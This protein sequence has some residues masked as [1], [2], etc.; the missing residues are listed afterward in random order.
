[1][2][3]TRRG[4]Q[5]LTG[6]GLEDKRKL[7]DGAFWTLLLGSTPY[8]NAQLNRVPSGTGISGALATTEV[9]TAGDLTMGWPICT[10]YFDLTVPGKIRKQT[11]KG[12]KEVRVPRIPIE[13]AETESF[14]VNVTYPV[15]PVITTSTTLFLESS[16]VSIYLKPLA[17]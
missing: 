14:A 6:A 1:M 16:L 3:I 2:Y 7:W 13:F 12:I 11:P 17:G 8:L 5:L 10:C 15:R 4:A 9:A